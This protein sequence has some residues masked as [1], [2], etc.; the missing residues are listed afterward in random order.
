MPRACSAEGIYQVPENGSI[1]LGPLMKA[2]LY[3]GV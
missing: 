3:G 1:D 2:Q